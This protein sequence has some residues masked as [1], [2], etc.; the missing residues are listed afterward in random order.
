MKGVS[1]PCTRTEILTLRAYE[2]GGV[3]FLNKN[4]YSYYNTDE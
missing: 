2:T 4:S 1:P 3:L